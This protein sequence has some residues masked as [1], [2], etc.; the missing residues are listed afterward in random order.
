MTTYTIAT[1]NGM[2]I[3]SIPDGGDIEAAI[4]AFEADAWGEEVDRKSVR[5]TSGCT[6]TDD[7]KDGDEVVYRGT[8]YGHLMD[9]KGRT[10]SAAVIRK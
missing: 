5:I 9:E 6:L 4:Q 8:T 7:V 2:L 3:A 1:I 10:Y